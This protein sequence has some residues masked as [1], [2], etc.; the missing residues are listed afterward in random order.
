MQTHLLIDLPLSNKITQKNL[1]IGCYS[2]CSTHLTSCCACMFNLLLSRTIL[3]S[4]RETLSK[5]FRLY[6]HVPFFD[7]SP[8]FAIKSKAVHS[9]FVTWA[10]NQNF[11]LQP[12][13]KNVSYTCELPSMHT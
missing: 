3:Y 8:K 7:P 9:C 1:L 4:S 2:S 12:C 6:A 5:K 13:V 11:V 10:Y